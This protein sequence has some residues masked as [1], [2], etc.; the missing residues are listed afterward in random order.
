MKILM[1]TTSFPLFKGHTAGIFIYEQA[2]SFVNFGQEVTIFAP[3]D[4]GSKKNEVMDGIKVKRFSYFFKKH[5]GLCYG[6]GVPANMKKGFKYKIQLPMLVLSFFIKCLLSGRKYDV[7]YAHWTLSGLGAVLAGKILRKPVVVMIH[8]GQENFNKFKFLLKIPIENAEHVVFNSSFTMKKT[9]KS[10]IPRSYSV[11][12][13]G[14]DINKFKSIDISEYTNFFESYG[15]NKNAKVIF[16][17]GRHIKLKGYNYL[18]KAFADIN[19]KDALLLLAGSGPETETL[20]K[21]A[22]KLKID[23]RIIF[24]G[25]IPNDKTP[26]F[27]NRSLLF[28]QPS[29]VDEHGNTEGLGVVILEAMACGTPVAASEVGGIVDI[30]KNGENGFFFGQKNVE[31]L[32]NILKQRINNTKEDHLSIQAKSFVFNNYSWDILT[33]K[34]LSLLLIL[35]N[36]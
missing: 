23:D 7:I 33:K 22:K 8:H 6:A 4:L 24:A 15:I 9:L 1:T 31:K 16:S 21:L 2:K 3:Y 13:P 11:I 5:Q 10:F 19:D 35:I 25:N 26:L 14:V 12:P 20:K 18:I 32:T 36:K 27:Y 34:N 30:I 28:V 17:M 29:I